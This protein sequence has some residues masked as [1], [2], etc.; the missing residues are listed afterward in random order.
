MIT[1]IAKPGNGCD[2]HRLLTPLIYLDDNEPIQLKRYEEDETKE[3][4]ATSDTI[5]FNRDLHTPVQVIAEWKEEYGFKL[6]M[7]LDDYWELPFEHLLYYSWKENMYDEKIKTFL[8]L[9]DHVICTTHKLAEYI[10]PFNKSVSVIPNCIDSQSINRTQSD[11]MR[12]IYAAGVT[13]APDVNLLKGRFQRIATDPYIKNNAKFILAGVDNKKYSP[14]WEYMKAIF[15]FTGSYELMEARPLD[16]YIEF[17]NEADV[18]IMPLTEN[19]FNSCKSPLKILE[20][21]TMGL[22]CIVSAVEPFIQLKD[23]PGILWVNKPTDWLTHIRF[24]IKNP[25]WVKE[26]GEA[27]RQYIDTNFNLKTWSQIRYNII[28]SLCKTPENTL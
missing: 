22:P 9:A 6:I 12:F 7:D 14:H 21:G 5:I 10:K 16:K 8:S 19:I 3:L 24:C 27:L 2:W 18:A 23:A 4:F 1:I 11:K 15:A 26:Q 25:Q 13:H 28:K 20:A 17:Y